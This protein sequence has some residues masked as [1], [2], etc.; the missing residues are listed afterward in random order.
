MSETLLDQ[1]LQVIDAETNAWDLNAGEAP[2]ALLWP[3]RDSSG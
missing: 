1:I 3:D 2:V